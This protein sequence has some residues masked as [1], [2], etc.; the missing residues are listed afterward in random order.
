M[1]PVKRI[2]NKHA[3]LFC[4]IC[5]SISVEKKRLQDT[6]DQIRKKAASSYVP[7]TL[8]ELYARN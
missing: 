3:D 4:A 5:F 6:H 2:S 1:D 7:L 8:I